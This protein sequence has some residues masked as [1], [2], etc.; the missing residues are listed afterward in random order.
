MKTLF[1]VRHAKAGWENAQLPDFERTLTDQGRHESTAMARRLFNKGVKP[2]LIVSSPATRALQTAEIFADR[3]GYPPEQILQKVGIYEGDVD[4]LAGIV[5]ELPKE[6][7]TVMLFGHN[8][9]ISQFA[10]WLTGKQVGQM[11]TC[12]VVQFD[13]GKGRWAS[14]KKESGKVVWAGNPKNGQ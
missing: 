1:L 13:M 6:L 9:T 8:P 10:S 4:T 5:R 3:L 2:E 7:G 12:S 11:E 14:V